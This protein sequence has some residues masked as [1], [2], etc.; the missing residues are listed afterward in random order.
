MP[1]MEEEDSDYLEDKVSKQGFL[2]DA[3]G[4]LGD[5]T[6]PLPNMERGRSMSGSYQYYQH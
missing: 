5:D 3:L 4:G 1:M 2:Q 6:Y